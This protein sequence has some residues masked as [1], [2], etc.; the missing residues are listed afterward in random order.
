M[1]ERNEQN[2]VS[3]STHMENEKKKRRL[4]PRQKQNMVIGIIIGVLRKPQSGRST[5]RRFDSFE[6]KRF[7]A[8][9]EG[10]EVLGTIG[11]DWKNIYT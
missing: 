4:G 8:Q 9:D 1:G 2:T 6:Q 3:K 5:I 11:F 10:F 7:F